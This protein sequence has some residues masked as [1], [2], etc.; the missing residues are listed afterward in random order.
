MKLDVTPLIVVHGIGFPLDISGIPLVGATVARGQARTGNLKM[1]TTG[2]R[3]GYL[4]KN[5]V[6]YSENA[7]LTEYYDRITAPN[8]DQWLVVMTE[9]T[10]PRYLTMPF[11]TTTHFKKQADA[12]GW[13]PEACTAR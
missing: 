10:D 2:L 5:G 8:G 9:V 1:V 4:R 7:A 12:T 3:A 6:P 13:M 11:V